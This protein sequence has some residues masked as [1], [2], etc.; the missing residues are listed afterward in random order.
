MSFKLLRLL[1]VTASCFLV[2][3]ATSPTPHLMPRDND[4][5]ASSICT[6]GFNDFSCSTG[7]ATPALIM[8]ATL[9]TWWPSSDLTRVGR[10]SEC[11]NLLAP[12]CD[13]GIEPDCLGSN[14]PVAS[15]FTSM[16]VSV[17]TRCSQSAR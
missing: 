7:D 15:P 5:S 1:L 10:T 12:S 17:I 14:V 13:I 3:T 8:D 11:Y 6:I 4:I 2:L 9:P 16:W